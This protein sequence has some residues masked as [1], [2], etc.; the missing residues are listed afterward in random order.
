MK[1]KKRREREG[2]KEGR[3]GV[4]RIRSRIYTTKVYSSVKQ[5]RSNRKYFFTFLPF[6]SPRASKQSYSLL[7]KNLDRLFRLSFKKFASS[8]ALLKN[9]SQRGVKIALRK[10]G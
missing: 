8:V 9:S 4:S 3:E 5:L 2:K 6:V 7:E 1:R 10:N